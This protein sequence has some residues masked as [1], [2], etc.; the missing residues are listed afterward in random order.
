M[1][2]RSSSN[3]GQTAKTY[4]VRLPD[5]S[6]FGP[7]GFEE[8]RELNRQRAL[9]PNAFVRRSTSMNWRLVGEV[10]ATVATGVANPPPP[11]Q[12]P[13]SASTFGRG[14]ATHPSS[15]SPSG[16]KGSDR[17]L[18]AW[19]EF[20]AFIGV[21]IVG[22]GFILAMQHLFG[23]YSPTAMRGVRFLIFAVPAA[24]AGLYATYKAIA[25]APTK[26]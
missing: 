1:E 4:F 15:A 13:S 18:S 20:A 24:G 12:P 17:K 14:P 6:E 5:G 19:L 21:V 2:Q 26:R 7:L 8:M 11:I 9:P 22:L 23:R 25:N 10:M 3:S 16:S